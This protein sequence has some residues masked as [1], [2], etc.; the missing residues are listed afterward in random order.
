MRP[1]QCQKEMSRSR[2]TAKGNILILAMAGVIL[3]AI[4]SPYLIRLLTLDS[5]QNVRSRL[6]SRAFQ[7]AEAGRA[8]AESKLQEN[9]SLFM[10]VSS[11]TV[12]VGYNDDREFSDV[13]GGVYKI[14]MSS[15][16]GE[17]EV[18]VVAKGKDASNKEI[19]VIQAVY[20][21]R[22]PLMGPTFAEHQMYGFVPNY[23]HWGPHVAYNFM[24]VEAPHY[25]RKYCRG[26]IQTTLMGAFKTADG[27]EFWPN[28]ESLGNKMPQVDLTYYK[29]KALNSTVPLLDPVN[30]GIITLSDGVTAPTAV[31]AAS[32]YFPQN[33]SASLGYQ[34][35]PTGLKYEFRSSTSVIYMDSPNNIWFMNSFLDVE[36]LVCTGGSYIHFNS[37][38][39]VFSATIPASAPDEYKSTVAP[40]ANSVWTTNFAAAYGAPGHCCYNIPKTS[41]H[42]L[43]VLDGSS[44]HEGIVGS[45]MV[46]VILG[47][48]LI[49][50]QGNSTVYYD[51]AV[52]KNIRWRFAP[53]NR[54]SWKE[55]LLPW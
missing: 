27:I 46:G 33:L 28:E 34:F 49:K 18:T 32:G 13:E 25:P 51:E 30:G 20:D 5:S 41:F 17:G 40:S 52:G 10:A 4:I 26:T 1:L 15:G 7:L 35:G 42:G 53:L 48:N 22:P 43:L 47:T 9:S 45:A 55:P 11:G 6:S 23:A 44:R 12:V 37:S 19:R 29:T 8:R 2:R 50:A 3:L 38:Y 16:P 36:A 24:L 14:K 21:R 54:K 39:K 31:P